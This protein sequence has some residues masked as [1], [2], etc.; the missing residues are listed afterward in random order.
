LRTSDAFLAI[1]EKYLASEWSIN[2]DDAD[3]SVE[4]FAS[5]NRKKRTAAAMDDDGEDIHIARMPPKRQRYALV[6]NQLFF[7]SFHI[8]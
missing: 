7:Q 8:V 5:R 2:D 3:P 1:I 4:R 6:P